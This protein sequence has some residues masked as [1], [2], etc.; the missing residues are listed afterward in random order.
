MLSFKAK[1]RD[2]ADK[3]SRTPGYSAGCFSGGV[4]SE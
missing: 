1:G 2:E 4:E 3:E